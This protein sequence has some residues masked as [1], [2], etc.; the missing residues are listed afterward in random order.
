VVSLGF[1]ADGKRVRKKV[2]GKA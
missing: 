2:S 1:N